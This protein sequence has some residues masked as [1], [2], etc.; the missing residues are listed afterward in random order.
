[1]N[2]QQFQDLIFRLET[3]LSSLGG[4][5]DA[6]TQ[7]LSQ[8]LGDIANSLGQVSD[9]SAIAHNASVFVDA[10]NRSF[11]FQAMHPPEKPQQIGENQVYI[12][13]V[14][15]A[16]ASVLAG[17]RG[18][19]GLSAG[20]SQNEIEGIISRLPLVGPVFSTLKSITS[21]LMAPSNLVTLGGMAMAFM[22]LKR[23]FKNKEVSAFFG[24]ELGSF[25]DFLTNTIGEIIKFFGVEMGTDPGQKV[26][27]T[28]TSWRETLEDEIWMFFND[29]EGF[30]YKHIWGGPTS[31]K[32]ALLDAWDQDIYSPIIKQFKAGMKS[33]FKIDFDN[34]GETF[35]VAKLLDIDQKQIDE[36][37]L[38]LSAAVGQIAADPSKLL[39]ITSEQIDKWSEGS[40]KILKNS[41]EGVIKD[42][43]IADMSFAEKSALILGSVGLA[44][45]SAL[46]SA[47][48]AQNSN[49]QGA[50]AR[51]DAF[52]LAIKEQTTALCE[53]IKSN[54]PQ[55]KL[56]INQNTQ[57][58]R[59]DQ[60]LS[61]YDSDSYSAFGNGML[62]S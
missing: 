56:V 57:L 50:A 59:N 26:R 61:F 38:N 42:F 21:F 23:F 15:P 6:M 27:D 35:S 34:L 8:Q 51:L 20:A 53:C 22:G 46:Q 16:A 10:L 31:F 11:N 4:K 2:D 47:E 9:G 28:F 41:A 17:S 62:T 49:Q 12:A 55:E 25:Y 18:S 1:M 33:I 44:S 36:I 24:G 5:Q 39:G 54:T 52:V 30:W 13:G 32:Q 45:Q 43:G 7:Q 19:S 40:L 37:M 48:E 60:G 14:T 29:E 3:S 58:P